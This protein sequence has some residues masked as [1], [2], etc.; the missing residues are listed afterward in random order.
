MSDILKKIDDKLH[1]EDE[2]ILREMAEYFGLDLNEK[3]GDG[4][5]KTI[6]KKLK[7]VKDS[8]NYIIKMAGKVAKNT[9]DKERKLRVEKE[10]REVLIKLQALEQTTDDILDYMFG[11]RDLGLRTG[12]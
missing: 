4:V 8:I 6:D 12:M 5:S 10:A 3:L 11:D 9:G 1:I 7:D 2:E